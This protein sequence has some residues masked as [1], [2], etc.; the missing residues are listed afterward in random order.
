VVDAPSAAPTTPTGV[1]PSAPA[2]AAMGLLQL[3]ARRA[4]WV[5]VVDGRSNVLIART[6]A[7]GEVISLDGPVPMRV[8]VGNVSGTELSFRGQPVDLADLN[9]DNVARLELK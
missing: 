2:A 8:K 4:S 7:E 5:E 6:L 9:R 1:A 3:R